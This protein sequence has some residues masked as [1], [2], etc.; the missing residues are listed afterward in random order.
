MRGR[1]VY[2]ER[3][4][5]VPEKFCEMVGVAGATERMR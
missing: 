5:G 2:I 3:N 4:A 1:G